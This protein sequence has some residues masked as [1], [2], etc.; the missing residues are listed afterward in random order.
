M[1]DAVA[2][3]R[4]PRALHALSHPTRMAMLEALRGPGSAASVAR[5]IGLTR[6]LA[7]YHLKELEKAGLV[8]RVDER[9]TGN[10][11]ESRYQAVARSFVVSPEVARSHPARVRALRRQHALETLVELG[12]RLQRDAASLLDRA[13]FDGEEIASAGVTA[14]VRFASEAARAAFMD[15]YL[16]TTRTLLERHGAEEGEGYRVVL[17]VYPKGDE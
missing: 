11:V 9:R 5:S 4:E 2:E 3:I 13:A 7:N 8:E 10:F 12:E 16:R 15:E 6:Q 1:A 14:E 17:A